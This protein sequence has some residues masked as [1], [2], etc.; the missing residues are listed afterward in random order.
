MRSSWARSLKIV[1]CPPLPGAE[2]R[3]HRGHVKG[4]VG[5]PGHR[6]VQWRDAL[7]GEAQD[8]LVGVR[9][10]SVIVPRG[11]SSTAGGAA[12]GRT[13]AFQRERALRPGGQAVRAGAEG[14][15]HTAAAVMHRR[16]PEPA[17]D[18]ARR[19]APVAHPAHVALTPRSAALGPQGLH[20]PAGLAEPAV[21]V[22]VALHEV[23]RPVVVGVAHGRVGVE[24]LRPAR[25]QHGPAEGL[26][27]AVREIVEA[28][29]LP[30]RPRVA[31]VHV[32][33][34]GEPARPLH[35]GPAVGR[36]AGE[37]L[38]QLA[39]DHRRGLR[40]RQVG[41]ERRAHAADRARRPR[42]ARRA[43]PAGAWRPG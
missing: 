35:R 24:D 31:G 27:L 5:H 38:Q 34:E 11:T 12:A 33:E 42:G 2:G 30:A 43:S 20:V 17:H 41:A 4:T 37:E 7:A 39:S 13:A 6:V 3:N 19:H 40:V 28:D 21:F 25:L 23:E 1:P 9:R 15:A 14:G 10:P 22:E 18:L 26:V 8:R 36:E 29:L 16:A 32:R